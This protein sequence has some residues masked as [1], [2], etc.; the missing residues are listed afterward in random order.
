M[1]SEA[2]YK[3]EN[4]FHGMTSG[5]KRAR[6]RGVF[7]PSGHFPNREERRRK[8][9]GSGYH[10]KGG[11]YWRR[12]AW[13]IGMAH[14]KHRTLG[15]VDASAVVRKGGRTGRK[16]NPVRAERKAST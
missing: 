11:A 8:S 6:L 10:E 16:A 1:K 14:P 2:E 7:T 15:V 4:P 5:Q 12:D 9:S 3:P 13:G